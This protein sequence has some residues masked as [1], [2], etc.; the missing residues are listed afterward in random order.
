[1]YKTQIAPTPTLY[2]KDAEEVLKQ[3]QHRPSTH[4]VNKLKKTLAKKFECVE[5]RAN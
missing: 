2:G 5:I 3:V 4:E 1:M